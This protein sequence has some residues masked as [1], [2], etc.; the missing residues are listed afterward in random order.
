[1]R[2]RE[3]QPGEKESKNKQ[4]LF[5]LAA[6]FVSG[7]LEVIRQEFYVIII[8]IFNI[9]YLH[10]INHINCSDNLCE[11]NFEDTKSPLRRARFQVKS[12]QIAVFCIG[13][14]TCQDRPLCLI[15][16][17]LHSIVLLSIHSEHFTLACLYVTYDPD[18][19]QFH[20]SKFVRSRAVKSRIKM[21]LQ[22]YVL[23]AI[24]RLHLILIHHA[25]LDTGHGRDA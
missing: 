11:I 20:W 16:Q 5:R 23:D 17:P 19:L 24:C 14:I 25:G 22:R 3:K 6:L 1:M 2:S 13:K 7:V 9:Y 12:S 21:A 8:K 18:I 4:Y 10:I 15:S